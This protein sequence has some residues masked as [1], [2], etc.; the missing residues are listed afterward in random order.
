M[1][2]RFAWLLVAAAALGVPA[3]AGEAGQ[4]SASMNFAVMRN[5]E[6]IGTNRIRIGRDGADT[7]VQN[8]THVAVGL[9][10]LTLYRY[11]QNETE[12]W[13]DG[14]LVSLNAKTDDNGTEHSTTAKAKDG[15]LVVRVDDKLSEAPPTAFPLSLWNA[16]VLGSGVALDPKDGSVQPMKVIDRG[17]EK[18]RIQ[19]KERPVH[20]YAIVTTFQQEVWYDDNN[21][22]VQ[23]EL[24]GSDGSTIRYQLM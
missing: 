16:E 5:G 20:H 7:T 12:R 10:M 6:Q 9:G 17:Q 14:R 2:H 15:K 4:N 11:D 24:K 21:Q 8:D 22:L 23:V 3:N 13:A 19:G 18:L 1:T